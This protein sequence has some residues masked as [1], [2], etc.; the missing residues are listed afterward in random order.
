MRRSHR[1]CRHVVALATALETLDLAKSGERVERAD[2]FLVSW[3]AVRGALTQGSPAEDT[4]GHPGY[5]PCS[6]LYAADWTAED[7]E[8]VL[9]TSRTLSTVD[10]RHE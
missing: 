8:P 9:W 2:M 5:A 1:C 6:T 4:G 10:S 7:A 3:K